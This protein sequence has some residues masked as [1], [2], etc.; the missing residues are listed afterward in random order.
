MGI[1]S[2]KL[3]IEMFD[4]VKVRFEQMPVLTLV[5]PWCSAAT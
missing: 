5:R 2:E 1:S 3:N 4:E